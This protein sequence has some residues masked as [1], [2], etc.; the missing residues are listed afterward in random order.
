MAY[1]LD[2]RSKVLTAVDEGRATKSEIARIFGVTRQWIN[3]RLRRRRAE[4]DG[5]FAGLKKRGPKSKLGEAEERRLSQLYSEQPDATVEQ[6]HQRL[7]AAVC[8]KTVWAGLRRLGLTFK[9][10]R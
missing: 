3:Q 6:F 2:L 8:P 4:Q 10:R 7:G 1:S 5:S 9:K